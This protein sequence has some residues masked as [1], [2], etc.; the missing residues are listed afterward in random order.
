MKH[1]IVCLSVCF[2]VSLSFHISF[3]FFCS[4]FSI[5]YQQMIMCDHLYYT[6]TLFLSLVYSLPR[7]IANVRHSQIDTRMLGKSLTHL[8]I[9]NS[10]IQFTENIN[11]N[12]SLS[13]YSSLSNEYVNKNSL[14]LCFLYF[15]IRYLFVYT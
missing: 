3:D 10:S 4:D 5:F 9:N 1:S 13:F 7:C 15:I 12:D 11:S 2:S 6:Y 14:L 8:S